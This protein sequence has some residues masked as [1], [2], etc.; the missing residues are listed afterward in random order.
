MKLREFMTTRLESI[1]HDK[2]VY[3]AIE[4]MVDRRICSLVVRFPGKE[5]DCGV[6]TARDVVFKVL[7]K[8]VDLK[9]VK[10]SEIASRPML[11]VDMDSELGEVARL[12]EEA[13]VARV[14]IC[15]GEK[16][17]GVVSLID[18]MAAVLVERARGNE[19][20]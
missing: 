14:F 3:D 7:A 6:I 8:G 20:P 9:T 1:N 5:T 17:R 13:D 11:C 12:M 4:Q 19:F 10:A 15:D 2:S 16:V 18:L